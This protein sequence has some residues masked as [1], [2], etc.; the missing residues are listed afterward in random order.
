[1][2]KDHY[3]KKKKNLISGKISQ[4]FGKRFHREKL[5]RQKVDRKKEGF[6]KIDKIKNVLKRNIKNLMELEKGTGEKQGQ[7]EQKD[8]I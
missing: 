3:L 7:K 2:Q 5:P 8:Q 4:S 6:K 1:M